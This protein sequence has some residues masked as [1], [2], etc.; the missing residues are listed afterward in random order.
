MM[1]IHGTRTLAA[2]QQRHTAYELARAW[3]FLYLRSHEA[4]HRKKKRKSGSFSVNYLGANH[5]AVDFVQKYKVGRLFLLSGFFTRCRGPPVLGF[6][7][8]T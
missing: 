4:H 5:K 6:P 2:T 3:R 8:K 7:P 1:I